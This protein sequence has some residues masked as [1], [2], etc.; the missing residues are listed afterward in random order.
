MFSDILSALCY[1]SVVYVHGTVGWLLTGIHA[2]AQYCIRPLTDRVYVVSILQ[3]SHSCRHGQSLLP[4]EASVAISMLGLLLAVFSRTP[5]FQSSPTNVKAVTVI[6][7]Y[8][9][10]SSVR[11]DENLVLNV[12]RVLLFITLH[13]TSS[14]HLDIWTQRS[15]ACWVLICQVPALMVVAAVQAVYRVKQTTYRTTKPGAMETWSLR[16]EGSIAV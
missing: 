10:A 4:R 16:E 15:Q 3:I 1:V 13:R 9:L 2:A 6:V 11:Y 14:A 7:I 12:I 5:S 8:T